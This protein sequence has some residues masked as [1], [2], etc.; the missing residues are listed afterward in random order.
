MTIA[1]VRFDFLPRVLP[2]PLASLA[3]SSRGGTVNVEIDDAFTAWPELPLIPGQPARVLVSTTPPAGGRPVRV[4]SMLVER[5]IRAVAPPAKVPKP[6]RAA[7]PVAVE[8]A[9]EETAEELRKRKQREQRKRQRDELK[10]L[11]ANALPITGWHIEG[12]EPGDV[13]EA[14]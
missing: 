12:G 13:R 2:E 1:V 5:A 6:P 14:A 3:K 8:V 10:I 9:H 7:V 4:A 11:K